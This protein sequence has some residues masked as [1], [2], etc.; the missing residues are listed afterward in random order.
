M[1]EEKSQLEN[2]TYGKDSVSWNPKGYE[3][4]QTELLKSKYAEIIDILNETRFEI[5]NKQIGEIDDGERIRLLSIA[6]TEAQG[7]Q[8]WAVKAVTWSTK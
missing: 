7:A 3:N 6:I 5:Q 1:N 8:M 4:P 2:K